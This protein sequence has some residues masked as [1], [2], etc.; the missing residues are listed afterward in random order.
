MERKG[1]DCYERLSKI[2]NI[3]QREGNLVW[4]VKPWG[5]AAGGNLKRSQKRAQESMTVKSRSLAL[6][7]FG[8]IR[9]HTKIRNVF[10]IGEKQK[11]IYVG[12]KKKRG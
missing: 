1:V 5:P 9:V 10:S 11:L 3:S 2:W 4:N 7:C 6:L 8:L 12:L